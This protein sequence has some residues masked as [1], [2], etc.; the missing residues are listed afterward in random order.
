MKPYNIKNSRKSQYKI[1]SIFLKRWSPRA[2]SP[3]SLPKEDLFSLFEAARW[4]PSSFN[5]QPWRFLYALKGTK[6]WDLFYSFLSE[7]NKS[8]CVNAPVL[9]VLLSRKNFEHNEKSDRHHSFGAGSAW[10][11]LA[12]QARM[13]NLIAHGMAGFDIEKAKTN[14]QIPENYNVECMI[15]VGTQGEIE[16]LPEEKKKAEKPNDRKPLDSLINEGK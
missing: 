10:M 4:S 12:L 16:N 3:E 9:I 14:L 7:G 1:N 13:K 15:A 8:W 11:S 6:F 5:G 2:L